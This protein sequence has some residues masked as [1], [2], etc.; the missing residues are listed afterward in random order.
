MSTARTYHL[1]F[2]IVALLLTAVVAALGGLSVARQVAS[3]QPLG[4]TA[5]PAGGAWTVGSVSDP[6]TGL[7]AGDQILTAEGRE[8]DTGNAL[9]SALRSRPTTELLIARGDGLQRILYNRPPLDVD[10]PYLILA[11]I[12]AAYLL[13]GFYTLLKDGQERRDHSA[14]SRL[15]FLW[16]LASATFYLLTPDNHY[17]ALGRLLYAGDL[18]GR[19]FLPPLTL[20]LFLVFPTWFARAGSRARFRAVLPF[21]YLPAVFLLLVEADLMAGT[22]VLSGGDARA[23]MARTDRLEIAHLAVFALAAV[24][25][26]ALRLRRDRDWEGQRQ[27]RW[28]AIGMLGGYLPFVAFYAVPFMLG[29]HWPE[30]AV[31]ASVLPLL[32]VPVTFAYAI[33]RYKLWDIEVMVRD[34]VSYT[35]TLLLGVI[36]FSLAN[37]AINRGLPQ[38]MP[39]LRSVL[40]FL[41]G[42]SIAGVLVPARRGISGGLERLQY[43]GTFGKRQAL[44]DFGRELLQ[45]RDLGLLCRKLLAA[46]EETVDLAR[47][48]LYLAAGGSLQPVRSES[49]LPPRL[50]LDVLGEEIW[51]EEARRLGGIGLPGPESLPT[52]RLYAA[53]YRYALPLTVHGNPVGLLLTGWKSGQERL[54]SDDVALLRQLLDRASLAIENA[55]LV[56]ELQTRLD[57]VSRLQQYNEGIIESSPA[58]IAVLDGDGFIVTANLGLARML[59]EERDAL[60]GRRLSELLPVEPLPEAGSG[61][62]QVSFCRADGAERHLQISTALLHRPRPRRLDPGGPRRQRAGGDGGGAQGA[63]PAGRPRGDGRRRRA[64]GQHAAH[65][66]LQ[67]RPDAARRHAARRPAPRR[68]AQGGAPDLPRRPHRPQ[69]ARLRPQPLRRDGSRGAGRRGGRVPGAAARAAVEARHPGGLDGTAGRRRRRPRRGRRAAAGDHQ[70]AAQRLR[71]DGGERRQLDVGARRRARRRARPAGGPRHRLRHRRGPAR[72][73]LRA[74]RDHQAGPRRHRPGPR[75]QRRHRAPPRR[76]AAGREPARRGRHLHLDAAPGTAAEGGLRRHP[77]G[78]PRG[79]PGPSGGRGGSA[80][81]RGERGWRDRV[82]VA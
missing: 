66:H 75:H 73:H 3:F 70:P 53:G 26:L 34:A 40:V 44:L 57:E 81:R 12:G 56:D 54:T 46:V 25:L 19:L 31:S 27:L 15:F 6:R 24:A 79:R 47:A 17:D 18:A 5:V 1:T 58:G 74:L 33:L 77:R 41:A 4:F 23:A 45:E 68:A 35:L 7:E 21:L 14:P 11:L 50:P 39:L 59:G 55:Q 69:P 38:D 36:G 28:V 80:G 72:A 51:Q 30:L 62:L 60:P 32:L 82:A 10:Y 29:V 61:P 42:L 76:R 78:R 65:R 71:R 16:C 43:R 37:L 22:G 13:I 52:Q 64:R 20:H 48:N 9:G 2:L 67:L 49:A 63:R 8:V